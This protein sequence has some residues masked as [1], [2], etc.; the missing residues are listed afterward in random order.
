MPGEPA[1]AGRVSATPRQRVRLAGLVRRCRAW[2]LAGVLLSAASC[3]TVD[4]VT[5]RDT[6]N[7]FSYQDDVEIG[8]DAFR[9]LLAVMEK[10]GAP[11]NQDREEAARVQAITD[12][13]VPVAHGATNFAFE[14]AFF[15]TNIVNA[16]A[17]PGGKIAVFAGLCD[18]KEGLVKDDDELAAVLAHEV[19]HVTC[20]HSTEEMTRHLPAQL[21]LAAAAVY[22]EYK[23]D[24]DVALAVEAAFLVYEGL[25]VPK[26]S[27]EDEAEADGVGLVYMA[28]A[29]YDPRAAVRLWKRVHEREGREWP[30]LGL[31][32]THPSNK[33]RYEALEKQ[34]PAALALYQARP[35]PR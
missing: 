1:P 34:L 32:S 29:G 28:R 13:I 11:G 20:R 7:V 23:E 19:A 35:A 16:F 4:L 3:A 17:F 9:E 24:E 2:L 26:Y 25:I 27:R 31:L 8:G 6:N 5:G 10:G 33:A 14:V 30:I 22:A 21:L 15:K 18:E 12:R